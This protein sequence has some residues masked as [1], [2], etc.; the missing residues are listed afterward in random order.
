M[1]AE[2][3]ILE[4]IQN[5]GTLESAQPANIAGLI[6]EQYKNIINSRESRNLDELASQKNE[7]LILMSTYQLITDSNVDFSE[8][9]NAINSEIS[10]LKSSEAVPLDKLC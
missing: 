2:L 8:R 3:S 6:D 5:P 10:E 4:K 7:F 9:I 1:N